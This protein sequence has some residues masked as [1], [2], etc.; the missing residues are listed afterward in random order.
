MID[1]PHEVD[2]LVVDDVDDVLF[3]PERSEYAFA[4]SLL[5]QPGHEVP[6]DRKTNVGLEHGPLDELQIRPNRLDG[7]D[8]GMGGGGHSGGRLALT[9]GVS[10]GAFK[11]N[12]S[13]FR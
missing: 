3:W 5:V 10:K 11:R 9:P 4:C 2:Q 13:V 12:V 6:N 7:L 8:E 1:R